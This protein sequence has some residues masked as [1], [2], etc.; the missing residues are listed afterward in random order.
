MTTLVVQVQGG[1]AS[2]LLQHPS[3]AVAAFNAAVKVTGDPA[4]LCRRRDAAPGC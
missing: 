1:A 3:G 4:P 2:H